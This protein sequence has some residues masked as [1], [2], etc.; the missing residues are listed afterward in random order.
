MFI[1]MLGEVYK[2]V[3]RPDNTKIEFVADFLRSSAGSFMSFCIRTLTASNGLPTI[4]PKKP[5][6]NTQNFTNQDPI[7]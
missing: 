2:F 3:H 7:F 5:V 6:Q 1:A 4:P